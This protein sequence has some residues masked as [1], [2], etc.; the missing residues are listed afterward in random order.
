MTPPLCGRHI[1]DV[2][3]AELDERA[4]V[5][6]RQIVD[7]VTTSDALA[8]YGTYSV[9]PTKAHVDGATVADQ[10]AGRPGTETFI[11]NFDELTGNTIVNT[12]ASG[13][14]P[15]DNRLLNDDEI[16][17]GITRDTLG[18]SNYGKM[19]TATIAGLTLPP[20]SGAE[21][22]LAY[23]TAMVSPA[24]PV[25]TEPMGLDIVTETRAVDVMTG[26]IKTGQELAI[27]YRF[28]SDGTCR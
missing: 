12:P 28:A 7:T 9:D 8:T 25:P 21:A 14:T 10:A 19:S 4:I 18:G 27:R 3:D 5:R 13:S 2:D 1:V 24:N 26:A 11:P 16:H 6:V 20:T 15:A 23:K 17:A 22:A